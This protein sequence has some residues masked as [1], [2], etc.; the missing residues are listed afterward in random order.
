MRENPL[1]GKAGDAD[2]EVQAR[3][4]RD[5]AAALRASRDRVP[6]TCR[7]LG[8]ETPAARWHR[9]RAP[10]PVDNERDLGR[11]RPDLRE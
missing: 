7:P 6:R 2:Q 10:R 11:V 3:A 9:S 8:S 4:D 1:G 5:D